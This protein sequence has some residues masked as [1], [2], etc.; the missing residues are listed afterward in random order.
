MDP[1]KRLKSQLDDIER[2]RGMGQM[3]A[4]DSRSLRQVIDDYERLDSLARS[5]HNSLN[6]CCEP[7]R[8]LHDAI[9]AAY[10]QAGKDSEKVW[11]VIMETLAPLIEEN[12]KHKEI[13]GLFGLHNHNASKVRGGFTFRNC[14]TWN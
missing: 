9:I 1:I 13:D 7:L 5:A 6:P 11:L 3:V 2:R 10:H 8:S 12:R 4:V 14:S